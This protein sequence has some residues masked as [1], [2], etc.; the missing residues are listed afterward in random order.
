MYTR[1]RSEMRHNTNGGL[2]LTG[3]NGGHL[4]AGLAHAART[5]MQTSGLAT[6]VLH[7]GDPRKLVWRFRFGKEDTSIGAVLPL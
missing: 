1:V 6:R 2:C 5:E 4:A 3:L 7:S